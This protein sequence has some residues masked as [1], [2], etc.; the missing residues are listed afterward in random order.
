MGLE[1]AFRLLLFNDRKHISV[2]SVFDD[3]L[4]SDSKVFNRVDLAGWGQR[5][6]A[7]GRRRSAFSKCCSEWR[8]GSDAYSS[9]MFWGLSIV[10]RFIRG[11]RFCEVN[12]PFRLLFSQALRRVDAQVVSNSNV[13]PCCLGAALKSWLV[14][15]SW[16]SSP[17]TSAD[18]CDDAVESFLCLGDPFLGG[19]W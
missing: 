16:S 14:S 17:C 2:R 1:G 4:R 19:G 10:R 3:V 12:V 18:P 5:Y 7:V 15:E 6:Y 9:S 13:L 11:W 8:I